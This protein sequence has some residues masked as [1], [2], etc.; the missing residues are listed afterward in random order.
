MPLRVGQKLQSCFHGIHALRQLSTF[1]DFTKFRAVLRATHSNS[2]RN[3]LSRP[4]GAGSNGLDSKKM[5]P[6]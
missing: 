4:S 5:Q 3:G 6:I 2:S 1:V